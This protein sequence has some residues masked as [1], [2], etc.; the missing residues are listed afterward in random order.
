MN[1]NIYKMKERTLQKKCMH[2]AISR[3]K[4]MPNFK[5]NTKYIILHAYKEI[6]NS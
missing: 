5:R 6:R 2:S 1:T 4:N 3:Q